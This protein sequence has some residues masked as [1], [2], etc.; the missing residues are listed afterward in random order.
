VSRP[1]A[2]PLKE[3]PLPIMPVSCVAPG[4]NQGVLSVRLSGESAVE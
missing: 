1:L 4:P 2:S 3:M